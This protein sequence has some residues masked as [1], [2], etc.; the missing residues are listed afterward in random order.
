MYYYQHTRTY[1]STYCTILREIFIICSKLLLPCL[2][3]DL[4]L[5]YTW[6]YNFIY[7]YFKN[8]FGLA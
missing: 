5:Y 6:V 3:T 2:I 4:R 7:T 1:F 8:I